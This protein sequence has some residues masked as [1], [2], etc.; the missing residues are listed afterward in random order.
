MTHELVRTPPA[1]VEGTASC[2][3]MERRRFLAELKAAQRRGEIGTV[4]TD[5]ASAAEAKRTGRFVV[6]YTRLKE[7]RSRNARY[8]AIVAA[9]LAGLVGTGALLWAAR[10]VVA[11]SLLAAA[12]GLLL[13][14]RVM[15]GHRPY[16]AGLHCPGCRG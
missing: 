6:R 2:T 3:P 10:H 14:C 12:L 7:P 8:V 16:C 5:D 13:T 15:A 11:W 1:Q 9:T 4:W